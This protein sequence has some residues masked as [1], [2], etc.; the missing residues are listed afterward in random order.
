MEFFD[1]DPEQDFDSVKEGLNQAVH[2]GEMTEDEAVDA[3]MLYILLG[4]NKIS[5]N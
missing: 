2:E 4:D 1:I 3:L 5:W